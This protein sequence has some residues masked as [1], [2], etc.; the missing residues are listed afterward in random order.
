[1]ASF[2]YKR[3][4]TFDNTELFSSENEN[5]YFPFHFHDHYCVSL[6]TNGTEV[7][8]NTSQEFIAPAGS[9]SITQVNEVHRN[10]SL[11]KPG[12][13]YKTI[14]LNPDMLRYFNNNKTV[15]ALQRVIYDENL[16]N[17]L[18]L[19]FEAEITKVDDWKLS[20]RS[21]AKYTEMPCAET[22]WNNRFCIIDEI[23]EEHYTRVID[24]EWLARQ[25]C[26][27]KFHFI[28]EFK[29]A[30][31]ISPQAYILLYRLGKSKKM[32]AENATIKDIAYTNGFSDPSHFTNTFKKFFGVSPAK[33]LH[34]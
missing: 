3:L 28:R 13:S 32:L 12:Y 16:Y 9:I 29:K 26:M 22:L 19:L 8:N 4:D 20:L 27:S 10:Y 30:K 1:M 31:G 17:S 7:L 15:A 14:Y 18:H 21:L 5:D 24:A 34:L 25:F 11:E 23:I 33:Y 6:I 2:A